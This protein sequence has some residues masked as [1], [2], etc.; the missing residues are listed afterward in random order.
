[1]EPPVA[2]KDPKLA[3]EMEKPPP[4]E[5]VVSV[6]LNAPNGVSGSTIEKSPDPRPEVTD[7]RAVNTVDVKRV[8]EFSL[9]EIATKGKDPLIALACKTVVQIVIVASRNRRRVE[10]RRLMVKT[11]SRVGYAIRY[12]TAS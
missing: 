10:V 7:S 6:R 8:V 5:T 2:T 12:Q 11:S 1:M 9:A 4:L 3:L